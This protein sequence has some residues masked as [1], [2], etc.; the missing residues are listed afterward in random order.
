[1]ITRWTFELYIFY[2]SMM[3][4]V[5][6]WNS[7]RSEWLSMTWVITVYV[8]RDHYRQFLHAMFCILSLSKTSKPHRLPFRSHTRILFQ[9]S[10]VWTPMQNKLGKSTLFTWRGLNNSLMMPSHRLGSYV[11][12][13]VGLFI[14]FI[15]PLYLIS[16]SESERMEFFHFANKS[17]QQVTNMNCQDG[18]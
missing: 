13:C 16:Q 8:K 2:D 1:M 10:M 5:Y 4:Q 11:A 18:E 14:I 6:T 17:S 3:F 7:N 12:W 9:E 15:Y